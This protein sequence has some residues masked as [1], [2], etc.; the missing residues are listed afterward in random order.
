M[1][2][3]VTMYFISHLK[4][5]LTLDICTSEA[6][7]H[8]PPHDLRGYSN[9]TLTFNTLALKHQAKGRTEFTARTHLNP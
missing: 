8:S 9:Y 4:V 7:R 2:F 6:K 1:L 3:T 5:S